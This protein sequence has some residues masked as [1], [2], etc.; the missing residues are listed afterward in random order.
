VGTAITVDWLGAEWTSRAHWTAK[1]RL[2]R[3]LRRL[4][5]DVSITTLHRDGN[6]LHQHSLPF[7]TR[8]Q[9]AGRVERLSHLPN[10]FEGTGMEAAEGVQH[11]RDK[12]HVNGLCHDRIVGIFLHLTLVADSFHTALC[13]HIAPRL[14]GRVGDGDV[15]Q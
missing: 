5:H 9:A 1:E 6:V 3:A 12:L 4:D 8:Q 14:S 7:C 13:C 15:T 10:D 11:E 2:T